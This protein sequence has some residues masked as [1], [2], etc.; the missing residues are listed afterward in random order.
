MRKNYRDQVS[1]P[2]RG[3]AIAFFILFMR[4]GPLLWPDLASIAWARVRETLTKRLPML[5]KTRLCTQVGVLDYDQFCGGLAQPLHTARP[6]PRF[7]SRKIS[8]TRA[9][10]CRRTDCPSASRSSRVPAECRLIAIGLVMD[11]LERRRGPLQYL[12]GA[13]FF[14]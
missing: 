6:F 13:G 10:L 9:E 4:L 14:G 3:I 7:S 11:W 8:S 1:R 2:E 5:S 12:V